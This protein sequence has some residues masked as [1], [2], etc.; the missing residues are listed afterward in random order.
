M[1]ADTDAEFFTYRPLRRDEFAESIVVGERN[2]LLETER[3]GDEVHGHLQSFAEREHD[4]GGFRG[5]E[6]GEFVDGEFAQVGATGVGRERFFAG[7]AVK[8]VALFH[9]QHRGPNRAQQR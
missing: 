4:P 6:T 7:N 1:E 2:V 8:L 9:F 3:G 5:G